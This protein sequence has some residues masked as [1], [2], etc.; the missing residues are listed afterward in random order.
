MEVPLNQVRVHDSVAFGTFTV[1]GNHHPK[2]EPVPT[3]SHPLMG[4]QPQPAWSLPEVVSSVRPRGGRWQCRP[5]FVAERCPM[6][7]TDRISFL[8]LSC[9]FGLRPAFGSVSGAAVNVRV[10]VFV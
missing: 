3:A 10:Q 1:L 4:M 5:L 6:V 9:M 8:H 2:T 7:G